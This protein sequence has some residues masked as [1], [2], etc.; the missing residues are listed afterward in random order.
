MS[1]FTIDPEKCQRDEI[2]VKACPTNVIRMGSP[3]EMPQPTPDFEEYCLACGHC[4]AVCPTEAFS[5]NWLSPE[6]CWP[7][8]KEISLPANRPNSFYDHA[9]PYAISRISRLNAKSWK[10]FWRLPVLR[11]RPKT[12]NPGTGR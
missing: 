11:R 5:L 6:K 2:C 1:L 4:V 10:S 8:G 3:D 12:A 9:V 7:L